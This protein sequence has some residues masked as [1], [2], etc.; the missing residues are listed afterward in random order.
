MFSQPV[1]GTLEEPQISFGGSLLLAALT[2]SLIYL[3]VYPTPLLKF[4][5][6]MI[7]GMV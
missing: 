3:G 5:H 7:S 2:V 4:I 6:S 1:E